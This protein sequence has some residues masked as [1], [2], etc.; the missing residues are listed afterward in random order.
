MDKI[1]SLIATSNFYEIRSDISSAHKNRSYFKKLYLN[2]KKMKTNFKTVQM[3]LLYELKFSQKHQENE[4][5]KL[6]DK[7]TKTAQRDRNA[8]YFIKEYI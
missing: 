8:T 4:D 1:K 5:L 6:N 3:A 7:T 2:S